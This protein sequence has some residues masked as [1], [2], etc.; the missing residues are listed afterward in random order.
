MYLYPTS[1]RIRSLF[2]I[3][4]W[5]SDKP[6]SQLIKLPFLLYSCPIWCRPFFTTSM[7][8]PLCC[9]PFCIISMFGPHTMPSFL[10]HIDVQAPYDAFLFVSYRCPAIYAFLLVSFWYLVIYDAFLFVSFRCLVMYDA[11]LFVSFR[12]SGPT[13]R[14]PFRNIDSSS[15]RCLPFCV[16]SFPCSIL[17]LKASVKLKIVLQKISL[18][19]L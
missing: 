13:W 8:S 19:S 18:Y 12:C 3:S 17:L 14:L 4:D 15:I 2:S 6:F 10:Y 7:F 9:F 5:E 16:I 11:F 1:L